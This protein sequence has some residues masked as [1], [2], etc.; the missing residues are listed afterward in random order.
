MLRIRHLFI[1]I[2]TDKGVF[3]TRQN[4]EDG[5]NI[6]RAENYA[7]KSQVVQAIM[8]ALGME[9]MQGPSHAVPLAH[10]L[11][12]YLEFLVSGKKTN[13][14]VLDS[15][16]SVEIENGKREF[17]TVQR[18]IAGDRHKHLITVYEGRALTKKEALGT[19]RDYFV[20]EPYATSSELG[21]HRRLKDFIG[22]DLPMAPRFNDV[23]CPLYLET[24]FPLLY[25]EQKLG[26]G[27][28]PGRYPTWLGIRDVGRR[29]VEFILGLDA[30]ATALEKTAVQEEIKRLKR[31][32]SS[33][34]SQAEKSA[35]AVVGNVRGIP[36]EP[37]TSWPP[38]VSPTLSVMRGSKWVPITDYLTGLRLRLSELQ[39]I[40][41]PSTVDAEPKIR[42]ELS[43]LE[44]ELAIQERTIALL[45]EK[46]ET[47]TAEAEALQQRIDGTND[48]LRKYKDLRKVRKLGSKDEP[49]IV[50]GHCPTC[51]QE[52]ADSL[53]DTGNK[54]IPM[55]VDQN[56]SFYEEQIQLFT[57]VHSNAIQ[58]IETTVKDL[59]A[60]R[61]EVIRVRER[62]RDIRQTLVS[63][64]SL[65]SI[66]A[67]SERIR[68]EERIARVE[69]QEQVFE[70]H[71]AELAQLA[72]EWLDVQERLKELPKGAL[73]QRDEKKLASL[74]T[75]FH[76]Q[77]TLYKMGSL[78]V[79]EVKI[80]PGTYEPEVAG[81]NLSADV[82]A[83][84]LIRLH[85]AYLLG[86]LEV[87]V[88]ATGNH[89]GL[90]IFDEPQQQSVEESAF[91]E[92]L[93]YAAGEK[94][95]QI[96]ITTSH[97][98]ESIGAYLKKIGVEHVAEFGDDRI[99]QKLS[100]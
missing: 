94:K 12:E 30:Y 93:R 19:G 86:L 10:A 40:E 32:W 72:S 24:I 55:T 43:Q 13:A 99:L 27:R 45:Y 44:N 25:V 5:L 78:D 38:E 34:R 46:F 16:V 59:R 83:S 29:T 51:H 6:I 69:T 41:I 58:S 18:A 63:P 2:N 68:L 37:I 3:G 76:Q 95:C 82:S 87:G 62:I 88:Q 66:E 42:T 31:E 71:I 75:S 15:M 53:L 81:V 80:S 77:L 26:W 28:L 9:G 98:R 91:R 73:S 11:T 61:A 49:E 35:S 64:T 47:D 79:A 14:K 84:D 36:V 89:P 67:I 1:N 56:V 8:Y 97:E 23:D 7:G 85:W 50:S 60:Q 4:F 57:A 39:S 96:I 21:F 74:Q 33:V 20:R 70:E 92:M 17:L 52:L 48:D 65:P 100:S 90:L 22:W 54:T